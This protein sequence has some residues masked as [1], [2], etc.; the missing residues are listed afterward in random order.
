MRY[1]TAR[2]GPGGAN[3]AIIIAS[4]DEAIYNIILDH[5]TFSWGVD[6]KLQPGI[7]STIQPSSGPL[8][9]KV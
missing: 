4:N 8:S 6:E 5:C 9:Q 1:I 3:H 2:P 7:G